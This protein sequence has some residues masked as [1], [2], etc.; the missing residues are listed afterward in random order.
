MKLHIR[1]MLAGLI[2][3]ILT[4]FTAN[5]QG[6]WEKQADNPIFEGFATWVSFINV[7]DDQPTIQAGIDAADNGDIVMVDEG[8]YYENINFKGKAITVAS[9]FL[10]DGDTSHIS[11][12]IIDGSQPATRDSASVVYFI[13]GEDTTTIITGFTI[14]GGA[15]TPSSWG[16]GISG[17]GIFCAQSGPKIEYNYII[18]NHCEGGG[19]FVC[20]GGIFSDI[21]SDRITIVRNNLVSG[22]TCTSNQSATLAVTGG[23]ICAVNDAII[24]DNTIINN[25]IYHGANGQAVGGGLECSFNKSIIINNIIK[26]NIAENTGLAKHPWGGGIYG[27]DSQ[28]GTLISGNLIENNTVT[29]STTAGGGIGL[30]S[31]DGIIT[32]DKNIIKSNEARKGGGIAL[33]VNS[34]VKITNNIIQGNDAGA[35]AGGIHIAHGSSDRNNGIRS[36]GMELDERDGTKKSRTTIPVIANNTIIENTTAGEGGGIAFII[37][38]ESFLAF[39]NIIYN[40]TAVSGGNEIYLSS[41][42]HAYLYNNDL[43][44]DDIGGSGSWEGDGNIFAD[45]EFVDPDNGDF[46]LLTSSPCICQAIDSLELMETTYYC[47]VF[48][49]DNN[50]RPAPQTGNHRF[51]DIGAF[52][53]QT[54]ECTYQGYEESANFLSKLEVYPNPCSGTACLRYQISDTRYMIIDLFSI[55]G[56]KIKRLMNEEKLSGTY[57]FEIDVSDLP[58]G[59]YFCTL[60]TDGGVETVKMIK[61]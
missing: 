42:A 11:N 56:Q 34:E 61:L 36:Y 45:P 5:S 2:L 6:I 46:H 49:I 60:K 48:D 20:G 17:G 39:N 3:S 50:Q 52:E 37:P 10:I 15:G 27:E 16:D 54:I 7:P 23:G 55:S 43:N 28:E 4:S 30:W 19:D 51:P 59:V 40:N 25:S 32:I 53:E 41:T 26:G 33:G 9:H 21:S 38:Y 8:T 12:T 35:R 57:E 14:Q 13:S 24:T 31:N 22:N 18:N 47:P 44:T 58:A 29:G 1:L